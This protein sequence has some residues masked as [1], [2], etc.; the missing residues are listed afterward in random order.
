[1]TWGI[2]VTKWWPGR[3]GVE[4]TIGYAPSSLSSSL[5]YTS[6]VYP[7][8]VLTVSAK[9]LLRV[10]LSGVRGVLH[11]GI[12]LG[13]VGHGD[14]A[15]PQWYIGP[16]TFLGGIANLG[17]VIKLA[18]PVGLR[19]DAE[20]FMYRARLGPCTRSGPGSGSVCDV[21]GEW[22]GRTTGSRLQNDIV[23][24]LGLGFALSRTAQPGAP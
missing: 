12:G 17:G 16:R 6:P 22:A 23:L 19:F 8:H 2:R 14:G 4:G 11:V 21:F 10:P 20:D 9:A 1:V 13:A 24:S 15:Y 18:G 5:A 7:A 3:L